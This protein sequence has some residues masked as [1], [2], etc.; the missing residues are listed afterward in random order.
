M[1]DLVVVQGRWVGGWLADGGGCV[2]CRPS[3]GGWV[4]GSDGWWVGGWWW[5]MGGWVE[6]VGEW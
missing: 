5:L 2:G 6:V 3:G 1:A 4:D